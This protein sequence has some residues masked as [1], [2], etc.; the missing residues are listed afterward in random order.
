MGLYLGINQC[1]ELLLKA[2][3]NLKSEPKIRMNFF[4]SH[5]LFQVYLSAENLIEQIKPVFN[6][7]YEFA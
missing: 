5:L 7:K 3:D 2:S 1:Y 4:Q 6:Q